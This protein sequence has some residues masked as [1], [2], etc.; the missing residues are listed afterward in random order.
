M[1]EGP[2]QRAYDTLLLWCSEVGSGPWKAFRDACWHL[3][4]D[5][6]GAVRALSQLGHIEFDWSGARWAAAPTVLVGIPDLPG[7]LLLT[8]ARTSTTLDELRAATA[9]LD[10]EVPPPFAQRGVGPSTVLIEVEAA[11]AGALAAAA[12]INL[13][14]D[15]GP[16][17]AALAPPADIDLVSESAWPDD[18]FGH[19]TIDPHTFAPRWDD[20][21][22]DG[23]DGLWLYLTWGRR[24]AYYLRRD[25]AWRRLIAPEWGPY[26]MDR[27]PDADKLIEYEPAHRTLIVDAAAPLPALHARA[28]CLCSGRLPYRVAHAEGYVQDRYVNVDPFLAATVIGRLHV[29]E[30]ET[31][32]P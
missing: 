2:R 18:R 12:G 13:I 22:P 11:D 5:P 21:T 15:A 29:T 27:P 9:G 17:L 4:L 30:S 14:A 7:R 32:T 1:S 20:P 23:A 26:A 10:V 24:H 16:R 3:E 8:G 31:V 25:G 28:M 6:S 19:C